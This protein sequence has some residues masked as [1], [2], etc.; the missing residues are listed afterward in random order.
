MWYEKYGWNENPFSVKPS[1]E[2]IIGLDEHRDKLLDY[3]HSGTICLLTGPAGIGKS[4]MLKWVEQNIKNHKMVYLDAEQAGSLFDL[5]GYLRQSKT[6]WERMLGYEYPKNV[7]LLLDEAHATE[8]TIK[9]TLKL[10]WDHD[11]IKSVVI[12]QINPLNNFAE[13]VRNRVGERIIKLDKM[14]IKNVFH[15]IEF[16]TQGKSPFTN[17]ALVFIAEDSGYIPRKILENCEAVCMAM[18]G[19]MN[20]TVSDVESVLRKTK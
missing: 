8:E 15:M 6:F 9:K 3:V 5:D 20:I 14:D 13:S 2:K 11:Y 19:K 1:A 10:H 4:S 16:R 17:E 12:T 7:V 18:D